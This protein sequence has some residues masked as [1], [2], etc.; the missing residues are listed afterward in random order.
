MG[1]SL[2]WAGYCIGRQILHWPH[3]VIAL[4]DVTPRTVVIQGC[5]SLVNAYVPVKAL[6]RNIYI[7]RLY[8]RAGNGPFLKTAIEHQDQIARTW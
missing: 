5:Q 4:S 1:S 3:L 6:H 2:L 8:D 7:R